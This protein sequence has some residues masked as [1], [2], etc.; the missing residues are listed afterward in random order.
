MASHWA[1]IEEVARYCD[2]GAKPSISF[3]ERFA[4]THHY[5]ADGSANI[6]LIDLRTGVRSKV[7][8]MA[9]GQYALFPHFRSDNWFYFLVRDSNTGDEYAMGQ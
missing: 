4:V 6:Y 3:D 1:S 8:T 7:T 5:E 9:H 2:Q